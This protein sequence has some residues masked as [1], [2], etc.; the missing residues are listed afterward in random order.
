M[1]VKYSEKIKKVLN[2]YSLTHKN[3]VRFLDARGKKRELLVRVA[4]FADAQWSRE[5]LTQRFRGWGFNTCRTAK[6]GCCVLY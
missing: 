2:K 6:D 1:L 3:K 5:I 4:T